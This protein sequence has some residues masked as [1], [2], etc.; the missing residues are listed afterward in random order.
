MKKKLITFLLV[1]LISFASMPF[2]VS[3]AS[4]FWVENGVLLEYTGNSDSVTIPADVYYIA[5]SV[6][7]DNT[8]LKSVNLGSVTIIGNNAFSGCIALKTVT[9]YENLVSC[10]AY[11]F[12][13]TP[14][15]NNGSATLIM[16]SVLVSSRATGSYTVPASVRS[17]APYAFTGNTKLTSVTVND[18]V[19]SIGE[20]AFYDCTALAAVTIS[21]EVSHIGAFAFE[22]TKYLDSSREE[23]LILGNGILTDVNTNA[24][25][26]V[27]PAG[28]KQLA[29]GLFYRNTNIV[30]VVIPDTVT[31]IGMRAFVGCTSLKTADLP[32]SLVV[33]EKEAFYNCTSLK[34]AVIPASVEIIGDSVYLGCKSLTTVKN[35]SSA[36]VS[37]GMFAGC[38]SLKY[39]MNS[40]ATEYVGSYAFYN[41]TALEEV[42]LPGT[43]SFIHRTSFEGCAGVKVHCYLESY[44]GTY[45]SNKGIDVYEIGDANNDLKYNIKDATHIQKATAGIVTL[46]FAD[47]LKA[48]ADF[49]GQIN[50][51]D[52]THIQ[53]K[54]AGII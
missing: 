4:D 20:A 42:S 33:L 28:V 54:L 16:G 51:R 2:S 45:L 21:P 31:S 30:S 26:V 23:F 19:S 39:V 18:G 44:T 3:A 53:K 40:S 13:G 35:N 10:G 11:A 14:F 47:S 7:Q 46:S 24:S 37:S 8:T 17:I 15:L 5:D 49:S 50:V 1:L 38:T 36:P 52:A 22:G 6:F 27:I 29:G 43:V 32:E 25:E 12:Y 48:D 41:C 34:N 9:S